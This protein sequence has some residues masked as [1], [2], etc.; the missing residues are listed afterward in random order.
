MSMGFNEDKD[1]DRDGK[2]DILEVAQAG[3]DANIQVREQDLQEKKF[4]HQKEIDK[5]KISVE[6]QKLKQNKNKK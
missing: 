3:V 6:K 2:P 4:K 5:E 1:V